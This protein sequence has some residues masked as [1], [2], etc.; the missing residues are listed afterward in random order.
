MNSNRFKSITEYPK[1]RELLA[2]ILVVAQMYFMATSYNSSNAAEMESSKLGRSLDSI[3][4]ERRLG[5]ETASRMLMN[6]RPNHYYEHRRMSANAE[7]KPFYEEPELRT[8]EEGLVSRIWRSN[9]SPDINSD[10]KQGSCWCSADDWC[11]CTPSLAIDVIL[12]SGGQH[13]WC[14]RRADTGKMALMGGF[15]EVGETSEESVHRELMEEMGL[16]LNT[17]P[18]L[19]GVYN[20]PKRDARRHT[21]SVVYIADVPV[22]AVPK[23]GDDATQVVRV[24]IGEVDKYDF[25]V[26]HKTIIHDY[27][28]MI[29]KKYADPNI[30]PPKSDD[31]E[32]FKRSVCPSL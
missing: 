5:Q 22:D 24:P 28:T 14:V 12:R 32:P 9:G 4:G 26:D 6:Q 11:M 23:A 7:L 31:Q 3:E 8:R 15:T 13:I 1:K 18:M 27:I 20:D 16:T 19:F 30:L 21:T 10:L 25:F 29:K 2:W 17:E